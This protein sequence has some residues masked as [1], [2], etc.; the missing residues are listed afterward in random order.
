L[1]EGINYGR[2]I[3][4]QTTGV[5]PFEGVNPPRENNQNLRGKETI[6]RRRFL[7]WAR[8]LQICEDNGL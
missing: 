5:V 8:D 6:F 7:Y 4:T 2:I 1:S 3:G